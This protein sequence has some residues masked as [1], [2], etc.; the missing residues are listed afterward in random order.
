MRLLSVKYDFPEIRKL[1]NTEVHLLRTHQQ[2]SSL[3]GCCFSP[4]PSAPAEAGGAPA[5]AS[6]REPPRPIFLSPRLLL[7]LSA[8]AGSPFHSCVLRTFTLQAQTLLLR[9]CVEA[10][11]TQGHVRTPPAPRGV[12]WI[13]PSSTQCPRGLG[14]PPTSS[15]SFCRPYPC[16]PGQCSGLPFLLPA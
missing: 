4:H 9:F 8:P 1:R 12:A 10:D 5:T 16:W 2:W 13:L 14:H 15:P 6:S 11:F 7:G 3:D